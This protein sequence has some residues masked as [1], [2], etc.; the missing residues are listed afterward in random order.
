MPTAFDEDEEVE[1]DADNWVDLAETFGFSDDDSDSDGDDAPCTPPRSSRSETR[2]RLRLL[3]VRRLEDTNDDDDGCDARR[4]ESTGEGERESFSTLRRRF[5]SM[6]RSREPCVT[7]RVA[8][9]WT[10]SSSSLGHPADGPGAGFAETDAPAHGTPCTLLFSNDNETFLGRGGLC[11]RF[12]GVPA[13]EAWRHVAEHGAGA[14]DRKCYFRVPLRR[15]L[16]RHLDFRP[17]EAVFGDAGGDDSDSTSEDEA[18]SFLR[19]ARGGP[20]RAPFSAATSGVW[21]SSA[22]C[23][24]PLHFDLCHGLLTQIHGRKRVLLVAPEHSRS[25]YRRGGNRRRAKWSPGREVGPDAATGNAAEDVNINTSPVNLPRWLFESTERADAHRAS[26][27][28][29]KNVVGEVYEVIL[30]PGDTLYTPPFWWHHVTTL[31]AGG[32]LGDDEVLGSGKETDGAGGPKR[33]DRSSVSL[34]L[35]FDPTPEESVHPC[36][37]DDD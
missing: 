1:K 18:S 22:G 29:V 21:V 28:N 3:P 27:P 24:T 10:S 26:F 11:E 33:K 6:F 19:A 15:E 16:W 13:G 2:S 4:E 37:D 5:A 17:V 25:L 32:V 7:R 9:Q 14:T 35:A 12:D 36:I 20:P 30:E 23:V 31:G 34:L 8:T